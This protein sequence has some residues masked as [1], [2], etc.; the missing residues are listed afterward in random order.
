MSALVLVLVLG[1]SSSYVSALECSSVENS[2]GVYDSRYG[3]YC[4][5]T[6]AG[7]SYC[8]EEVIVQAP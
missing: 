1:F 4:A 3:Y 5:G 8:W 7:C 6:G 2:H